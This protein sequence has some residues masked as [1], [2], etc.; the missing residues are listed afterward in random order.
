M[1]KIPREQP[2]RRILKEAGLTYKE[3]ERLT[4]KNLGVSEQTISDIA[5]GLR[6]GSDR[7]RYRILNALNSRDEKPEEYTWIDLYDEPPT[8]GR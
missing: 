2:L 6:R 3:V 1:T 4:A 8:D 7:S 5:R